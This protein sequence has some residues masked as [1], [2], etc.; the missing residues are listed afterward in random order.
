MREIKFRAWN[1]LEKKMEPMVSMACSINDD[2]SL[3]HHPLVKIMQYTG[4]K[5]KNGKEIYEGDV[6]KWGDHLQGK[7]EPVRI[8]TVKLDPDIQFVLIPSL[9]AYFRQENY[10]FH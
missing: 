4:M 8:A 5:D 2:G 6:V 7:E 10:T 1:K 3:N 9:S